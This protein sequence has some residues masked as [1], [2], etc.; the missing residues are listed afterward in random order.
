M[1]VT[2]T[3]IPVISQS[4]P[5]SR[6]PSLSVAV[7]EQAPGVREADIH[8]AAPEH[9]MEGNYKLMSGTCA[10]WDGVSGKG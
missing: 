10:W 5:S 7:V 2:H 8:V 9:V 4:D 3:V 6:E 1:R